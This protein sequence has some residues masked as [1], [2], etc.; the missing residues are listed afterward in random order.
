MGWEGGCA[1]GDRGIKDSQREMK[2]NIEKALEILQKT[3]QQA[4][5]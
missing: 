1:C 2:Q 3:L 4:V 5:N